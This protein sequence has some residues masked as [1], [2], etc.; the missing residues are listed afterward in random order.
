MDIAYGVQ[1]LDGCI[2]VSDSL[3]KATQ[4][5]QDSPRNISDHLPAV[6]FRLPGIAHVLE[7]DGYLR[8]TLRNP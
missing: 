1:Q 3:Y 4:S 6:L 5:G 7:W 2:S 8:F